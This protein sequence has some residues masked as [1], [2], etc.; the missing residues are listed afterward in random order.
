MTTD[1][2]FTTAAQAARKFEV[3]AERQVERVKR[4]LESCIAAEGYRPKNPIG[5]YCTS[6][7]LDVRVSPGAG[8][9][10]GPIDALAT[11]HGI[12]QTPMPDALRRYYEP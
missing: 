7:G 5:R 6:I 8:L 4:A 9:E 1:P 11:A 2:G 10:F 12:E 3:E